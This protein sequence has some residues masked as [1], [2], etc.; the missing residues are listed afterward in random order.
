MPEKHISQQCHYINHERSP[1]EGE[2]K[3]FYFKVLFFK[4]KNG[5]HNIALA[6]CILF[7]ALAEN[8]IDPHT[9]GWH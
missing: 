7:Y 1:G 8:A 9:K 6:C 2:D 3:E 5:G 4:K